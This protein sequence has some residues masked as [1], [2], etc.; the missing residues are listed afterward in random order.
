MHFHRDVLAIADTFS[1][2]SL[3]PTPDDVFAGT[4]AARAS[5]SG[6]AGW[7]SSRCGPAPATLLIEKADAG[8][9]GRRR[10][11]EHGV[12][13]LLHRADRPTAR[14]S[15]P[16]TAA[17]LRGAAPVRVGRRA[18][19][20]SRPGRPST[21]RPGSRI[22]DGIGSTEML[23]IFISRR[24]RRHPARRDRHG[25][26]PATRPRSSTRTASPVP[27]GTPGRLAVKGPTGCRYL[28]DDR[29]R[30]L[31]PGRLEHHR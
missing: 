13:V 14:C 23:H 26:C 3:Q 17:A 28:A 2:T 16:A 5:P 27:D 18:P 19:A 29:Q 6:S 25:R 9:A 22:I 24:R 30:S 15:R 7:W 31:R 8:R 20:A 10:S 4:P 21:T 12:T 1:R 11:A